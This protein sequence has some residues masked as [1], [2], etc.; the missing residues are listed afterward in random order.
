[1]S[2]VIVMMRLSILRI[3]DK[4]VQIGAD[5]ADVVTVLLVLKRRSQQQGASGESEKDEVTI[6]VGG[7]SASPDGR[8]THKRWLSQ[9]L[10]AGDT[11]TV[12]V[13]ESHDAVPSDEPEKLWHDNPQVSLEAKRRY[14]EMLRQ[15]LE[16][17]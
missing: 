2:G 4:R 7:Y 15:E 5:A 9:S 14:F 8:S 12:E 11:I 13:S 3:G 10:E 16:G 1:M 17:K 6:E